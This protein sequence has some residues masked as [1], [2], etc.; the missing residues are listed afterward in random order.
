LI[1]AQMVITLRQLDVTAAP[2]S[3]HAAICVD[4]NF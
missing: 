4:I 2:A 3:D 1:N